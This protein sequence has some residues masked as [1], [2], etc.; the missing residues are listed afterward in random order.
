MGAVIFK[1]KNNSSELN[2]ASES[3][4]PSE[5]RLLP[6]S[7]KERLP[8]KRKTKSKLFLDLFEEQR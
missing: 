4:K 7:R 6:V 3:A 5:R 8:A 1:A 2:S